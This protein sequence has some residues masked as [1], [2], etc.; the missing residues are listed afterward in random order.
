MPVCTAVSYTHLTATRNT[1]DISAIP[2]AKELTHL[3]IIGD[4]SHASGT[5]KYVP[6][7]AKAAIAAGA[8]GLMI[9]VY[10]RQGT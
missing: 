10:K 6:A 1:F 7:I 9:D 2:V 3:P 8:D 5:Y 4:P